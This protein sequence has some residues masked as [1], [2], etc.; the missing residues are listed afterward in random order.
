MGIPILTG[1]SK[2]THN[3]LKNGSIFIKNVLLRINFQD[4]SHLD[5]IFLIYILTIYDECVIFQL[6]IRGIRIPN[7]ILTGVQNERIIC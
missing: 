6:F 1:V 3:F 2:G 7:I 4:E 5:A